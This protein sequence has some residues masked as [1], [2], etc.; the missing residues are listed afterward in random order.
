MGYLVAS[1][2]QL[3]W[4]CPLSAPC[5]PLLPLLAGRHEKLKNWNV[6][7]SLQ[8]CSA[9]TKTS[10]CYQHCFSPKA[11]VQHCTKCYEENQ[12]HPSWKQDS[13]LSNQLEIKALKHNTKL[14]Y[15]S[16]L[17]YFSILRVEELTIDSLL[18]LQTG[19]HFSTA[20]SLKSH[21]NREVAEPNDHCNLSV[22]WRRY[23][24]CATLFHCRFHWEHFSNSCSN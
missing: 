21:E 9:T 20:V 3:S 5:V 17:I 19:I 4:F 10:V 24:S 2:G 13:Q 11:K 1:V 16:L 22:A 8:H 14:K 6:L 12:H 18:T 15:N 7:G 23:T